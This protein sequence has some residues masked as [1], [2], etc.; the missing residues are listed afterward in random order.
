MNLL[1]QGRLALLFCLLGLLLLTL[2]QVFQDLPVRLGITIAGVLCFALALLALWD[3]RS[4]FQ[5]M[6]DDFQARQTKS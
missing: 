1:S 5:Q 4:R 6:L 2:G 3:L